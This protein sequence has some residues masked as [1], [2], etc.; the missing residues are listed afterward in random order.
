MMSKIFSFILMAIT[1]V[2]AL[3]FAPSSTTSSLATITNMKH[4]ASPLNMNMDMNMDINMMMET[5]SQ[6]QSSETLASSTFEI[7]AGTIDPT[8]ALAQVLAGLL[9]SP[10]IL[11][12]PVLAAVSVAALLAWGIFSYASP[13]DPDE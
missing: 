11:L 6:I 10:I 4:S 12:V 7:A 3:A 8:T 5:S 9:G 13:A 1:I 2:Q